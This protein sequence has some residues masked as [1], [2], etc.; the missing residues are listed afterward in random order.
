MN[1]TVDIR[2]LSRREKDVISKRKVKGEAIREEG[3]TFQEGRDNPFNLEKV[4]N[5][6]FENETDTVKCLIEYENIEIGY[7]QYYP[8]D[9]ET[10]KVYGYLNKADIIFGIDQFIGE[11]KYW[12]RGIGQLLVSAMTDYLFHDKQ[13]ST[14]VMD[15]SHGIKERFVVM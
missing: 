3:C 12:D 15:P 11:V 6:F 1:T 14:V 9:F 2:R 4:Y 7:I 5:V 13:A 8:L 10:R